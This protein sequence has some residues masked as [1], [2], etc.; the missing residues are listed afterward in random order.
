MPGK[1]FLCRIKTMA[2][3]A[4]R[5]GIAHWIFHRNVSK[6]PANFDTVLQTNVWQNEFS[7]RFSIQAISPKYGR[8]FF[9]PSIFC[10]RYFQVIFQELE[11]SLIC[12]T[13]EF[14]FSPYIY[15]NLR[16][17]KML[18]ET[19]KKS[20]TFAAIGELFSL[21]YLFQRSASEDTFASRSLSRIEKMRDVYLG[22]TSGL[23][24][25]SGWKQGQP[26]QFKARLHA[27]DRI[28][29]YFKLLL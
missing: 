12:K 1:G 25:C 3:F 4:V 5:K 26:H 28:R 29:E 6:F 2:R 24:K 21:S 20:V 27:E 8:Q 15:S 11:F 18:S 22:Q 23:P 17:S 19:V 9:S 13:L 16:Q 14:P 10:F 7:G